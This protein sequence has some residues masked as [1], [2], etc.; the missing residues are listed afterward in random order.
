MVLDISE[1][2]GF[3]RR[4]FSCLVVSANDFCSKNQSAIKINKILI[5]K[6]EK[7]WVLALKRIHSLAYDRTDFNAS[8]NVGKPSKLVNGMPFLDIF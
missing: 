7:G 2:L 4:E 6:K 5:L 3:L 1:F 8:Y